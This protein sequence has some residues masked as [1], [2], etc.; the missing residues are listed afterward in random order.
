MRLLLLLLFL[1]FFFLFFFLLLVVVAA[2]SVVLSIH[3][4]PFEL[5]LPLLLLLLPRCRSSCVDIGTYDAHARDDA[6]QTENSE[7]VRLPLSS[8]TKRTVTPFLVLSSGIR[9][10]ELVVLLVVLLLL[11][12]FTSRW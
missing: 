5:L 4:L 2:V 10:V 12:A 11:V 7:Q 8:C 3:V 9:H 1:L 6:H